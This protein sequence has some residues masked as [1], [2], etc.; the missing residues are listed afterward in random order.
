MRDGHHDRGGD[1]AALNEAYR[2]AR[3]GGR[4]EPVSGFRDI[5]VAILRNATLEPWLP[6]VFAAFVARGLIPR[7]WLG[8]YA[9]YESYLSGVLPGWRQTEPDLTLIYIDPEEL[10]G[11]GALLG[12]A[13]I[14]EAVEQRL[15]SIAQLVSD[16]ASGTVVMCTLSPPTHGFRAVYDSQATTSWL[17]TLRAANLGLVERFENDPSVFILDIDTLASRFG[18]ARA[19]DSR[20]YHTAHVPFSVEFMS[21]AARAFAAV[22]TPIFGV[23]RKCVAVDAD[24]TLWGGILGEDGP[25]GLQIG[26]EYPGSL[27]RRFHLFLSALRDQGVLLALNTKNNEA[28][29][30][31]FLTSSPDVALRVNDFAARRINWEDKASN[32]RELAAELNI[33]L[34][35]IVFVDDSEVE[36]ELIRTLMPE[37]LV[38]IFPND[39]LSIPEF[40]ERFPG[41]DALRVTEED[42]RRTESIRSNEQRERLRTTARDLDDFIRSLDIH[43]LL[44]CQPEE[45]L[46]RIA[47]LT[48]RTNQFNLTTR[49]YTEGEVKA[50]MRDGLVYTLAMKDRFSD[51]GTVGSAMV[52]LKGDE[53]EMDTLLLSCRAFGREVE[54]VLVDSVLD[55][56][57]RRGVATVFGAWEATQKNAMVADFYTRCGFEK[58]HGTASSA[59]FRIDLRS[60]QRLGDETRYLIEREGFL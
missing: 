60:R 1:L 54:Y 10:A 5:D 27:Y 37:V 7:L 15:D 39:P 26:S 9:V 17:S 41:V 19:R 56:L 29:V 28:D 55:D 2:L 51:Y 50:F 38:E 11:D 47:Q 4:T 18:A 31:D 23:A 40:I 14:R 57:A 36:C 21:V 35:S 22:A 3:S 48:Q 45:V 32:L 20:L 30:L 25:E 44:R 59:S 46:P 16:G 34:E 53:A 42:R 58:T 43:L 12:G 6:H 13:S 24:N 33:G 8:D 49:R 52:R